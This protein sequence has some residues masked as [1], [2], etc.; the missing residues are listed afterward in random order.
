MS[1]KDGMGEMVFPEGVKPTKMKLEIEYQYRDEVNSDPQ[2]APL[3]ESFQGN[4][5]VRDNVKM[6]DFTGKSLLATKEE[7]RLYTNAMTAGQAE[8]V[9]TADKNTAKDHTASMKEILKAISTKNYD[10]V[11]DKFTRRDLICF[12]NC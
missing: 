1:A 5:V 6:M 9:A 2:V 7:K 8:G 3:M 4:S 10:S 11:A 12:K